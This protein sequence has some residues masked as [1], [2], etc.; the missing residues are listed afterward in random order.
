VPLDQ[1]R[2]GRRRSG[3]AGGCAQRAETTGAAFGPVAVAG[4]AG[5]EALVIDLDG[6]IVVCHSEKDQAAPTFKHTFGY[7]PVLAFCDNTGEF[8]A[9]TLR[10]GNAGSNTAADATT[11]PAASTQRTTDR[12]NTSRCIRSSV[13]SLPQPRQLS[14]V[15][16][17]LPRR[18]IDPGGR[19][20]AFSACRRAGSSC[21]ERSPS[22]VDRPLASTSR[23]AAAPRRDSSET[24][25]SSGLPWRC[26]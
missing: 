13:F 24:S 22:P 1:G 5:V 9:A 20:C 7:H 14:L 26:N 8:L 12:L 23:P 25:R 15:L 11:D 4:T 19:V 18:H 3:P 16:V 2:L 10:P 21:L 17:D 6:H